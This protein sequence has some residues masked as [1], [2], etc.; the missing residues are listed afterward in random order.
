[1]EYINPNEENDILKESDEGISAFLDSLGDNSVYK[2]I[3]LEEL[4][5]ILL[6]DKK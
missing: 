1:M 5:K 4:F 6:K 3:F 2:R